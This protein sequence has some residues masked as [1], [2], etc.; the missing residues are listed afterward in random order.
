MQ[1]RADRLVAHAQDL[2]EEQGQAAHQQTAQGRLQ[3]G[4]P[5]FLEQVL[6]L[7]EG[8]GQQDGRHP[9]QAAQQ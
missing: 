5:E 4:G 9:G 8:P 6:R 1:H 2:R 7:V 3:I